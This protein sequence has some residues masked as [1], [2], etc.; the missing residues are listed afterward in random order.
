MVVYLHRSIKIEDDKK[1]KQYRGK[2]SQIK[3]NN[4]YISID[5]FHTK[6]GLSLVGIYVPGALVVLWYVADKIMALIP[7][8]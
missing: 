2:N 4:A 5:P 8:T 3:R 6:E 1:K 7:Q